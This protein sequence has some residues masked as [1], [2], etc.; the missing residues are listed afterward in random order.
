LLSKRQIQRIINFCPRRT[1]SRGETHP[2]TFVCQFLD[3]S[4]EE[5]TR[6]R[7]FDEIAQFDKK[8]SG[9]CSMKYRNADVSCAELLPSNFLA[10]P[11]YV[12][13]RNGDLHSLVPP[14]R[15]EEACGTAT[16]NCIAMFLRLVTSGFALK[17]VLET[18][19]MS[20]RREPKRDRG[21]GA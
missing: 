2:K 11:N 8:S 20:G 21:H 12:P 6:S 15:P 10:H 14:L 18:P 9:H 1:G 19:A 13:I 4:I 5:L 7:G 3:R 17:R 16:T